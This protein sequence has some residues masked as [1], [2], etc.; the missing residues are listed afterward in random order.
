MV[1]RSKTQIISDI[2]QAADIGTG[3][4]KIM[5]NAFLSYSLVTKYVDFLTDNGMLLYDEK[6]RLYRI[7]EKGR[8][9]LIIYDEVNKLLNSKINK[10]LQQ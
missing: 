2:L 3:K 4:T 1:C 5:Y 6:T 9:F 7:L 10:T 8:R